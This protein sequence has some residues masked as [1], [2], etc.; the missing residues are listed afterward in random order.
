MMKCRNYEAVFTN[1]TGAP[2]FEF[3][4]QWLGHCKKLNCGLW[5]EL[6]SLVW[7]VD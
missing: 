1:P 5:T 3:T 2:H 7:T 4:D 6:W